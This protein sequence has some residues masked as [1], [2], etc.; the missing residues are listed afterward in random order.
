[1]RDQTWTCPGGL[2]MCVDL[3]FLQ[4]KFFPPKFSFV[5]GKGKFGWE[6]LL[7]ERVNLLC[8][9]IFAFS[10]YHVII[11]EGFCKKLQN[12]TR[13]ILVSIFFKNSTS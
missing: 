10:N 5:F 4:N 11:L 8:R 2:K 7:L 1:L 13:E 3:G 12:N 9:G 6:N